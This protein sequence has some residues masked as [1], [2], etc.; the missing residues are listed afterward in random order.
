MFE[1]RIRSESRRDMSFWAACNDEPERLEAVDVERESASNSR[2]RLVILAFVERINDDYVW[3]N[4]F[5]PGCGGACAE[6][7]H[8]EF[9]ELVRRKRALNIRIGPHSILN[10]RL[11]RGWGSGMTR[12]EEGD[13]GKYELNIVAVAKSS[14][15][16]ARPEEVS[17]VAPVRNSLGDR[18]FS[19]PS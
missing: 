1:K 8:D 6:R 12:E 16:E 14:A 19:R 4:G 7:L 10:G 3:L 11:E 17:A 2:H 5:S 9:L 15:E 18:G 13:R